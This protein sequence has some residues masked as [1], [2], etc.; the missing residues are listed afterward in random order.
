[1]NQNVNNYSFIIQEERIEIIEEIFHGKNHILKGILHPKEINICKSCSSTKVISFGRKV[2]NIKFDILS[3]VDTT[4]ILT[5]HK[6]K[7]KDCGK[8]FCDT[9][10]ICL[11]NQNI[12]LSL[13]LKVIEDL[14]HD[15][16]FTY[17][18]NMRGIS[19]QSV[20]D[21]FESL[22]NYDRVPFGDVLCVDEFK[23]L[24]SSV[25]KYAFIMFDPNSHKVLDVL[26][27][28][29]L[30]TI[31]NYL[32]K[33][34][35]KE[36]DKVKYFITDM[37]ESYR[38]VK[39][40]HFPNATHIVDTFH[41]CRYVEDAWNDVRIRV[42]A[43]FGQHTKEYKI[44]K[45]NWKI[46]SAYSIDVEGENFYNPIRKKY[47]SVET[48]IDDAINIHEDL[49]AAHVLITLFLKGLK[50][51]KFEDSLTWIENWITELKDTSIKEFKD[52]ADMFQ[53]WKIEI[54]N[55]FIRFGDKRLHNGYIEGINNKIK[56][57]K[58]IAYGYA[59]FT[60]FRNRIM[61]CINGNYSIKQVDRTKIKRHTRNKKDNKY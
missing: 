36:K 31:D 43:T 53:N 61:H 20:I 18:A 45:N 16:S 33:I 29:R 59:N 15:V 32:Y 27:D 41:F 11:K 30:E 25:G 49:Y 51:V 21:I 19:V 9:S 52:L 37:N 26:P 24:K 38:S 4:L 28:R 34:D 55:S 40:K 12:S 48:L 46:L 6:F 57:L 23:N 42:Q 3:D 22:I 8:L 7:C 13:K 39:K 1:M 10:P 50:E 60:H 5:Y 47:T 17:I 44:L 35:W 58:R 14:R 2:K 56:E 54:R